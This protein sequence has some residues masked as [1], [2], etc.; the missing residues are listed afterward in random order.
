MTEDKVEMGVIDEDEVV[1]L[2]EGSWRL[3]VGVRVG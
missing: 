1:G 2:G 3:V